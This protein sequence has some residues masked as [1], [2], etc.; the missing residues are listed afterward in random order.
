VGESDGFAEM[1]GVMNLALAEGM[2]RFKVNL[3][4]ADRV[5]LRISSKILALGEVLENTR[6]ARRP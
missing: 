5:G 2:I 6:T 4:A 3:Q 1:G